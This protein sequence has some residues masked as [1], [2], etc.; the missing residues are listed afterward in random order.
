MKNQDIESKN[1]ELQAINSEKDKFFS[2]IAHDVRGPL[3]SFL[4]LTEIMNEDLPNMSHDDLQQIANS[5]HITAQNLYD[6][7]SNLLDWSRMQRGI[8][9]HS[10]RLVNL[11]ELAVNSAALVV[12]GAKSKSIDLNIDIPEGTVVFADANMI[13]A[14][15]RNLLANAVKFT[16]AGGRATLTAS[17]RN[18]H[19]VE[20]VVS[21]TGIGIPEN[22][23]DNLFKMSGEANRRGTDGE[24]S[25][26]LGLLICRE[27]VEKHGSKIIVESEV[28]KGSTFRF[29]LP[30][31]PVPES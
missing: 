25:T 29:V 10:P 6:L 17:K 5:M 20:I 16:Q 4:S 21:D 13:A 3:G 22:L 8:V 31:K 12:D 30:A 15:I 19:E 24:L 23:M 1:R 2:I 28:G 9:D 27:F 14:V 18:E 7:L 11:N 26:G